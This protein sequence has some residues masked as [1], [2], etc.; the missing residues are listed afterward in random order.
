[1]VWPKMS[2]TMQKEPEGK[3]QIVP[4]GKTGQPGQPIKV[5]CNPT[6]YSIGTTSDVVGE[7]SRIKFNKVSKDDFTVQLF[8]DSYE[9][10]TDVTLKIKKIE[11][12]LHPTVTEKVVKRPPTCRF[13]WGDFMYEGIII[14]IEQS[15]TLFLPNGKPARANVSVTFKSV[16]TEEQEQINAGRE[17]CRK[18]WVVKRGDRLDL[19]ADDTLRDVNLWRLIAEANQINEPLNFPAESDIG[20]TIVIPDIAN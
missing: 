3:A 20:R 18:L 2:S 12:L 11:A 5:M 17:A 16:I 7:G 8:F 10:K 13:Q 6:Q 15:F 1:V 19:I 4:L 9:E 14:K